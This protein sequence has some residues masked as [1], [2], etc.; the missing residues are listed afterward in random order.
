MGVREEQWLALLIY[1]RLPRERFL[2]VKKPEAY[3]AYRGDEHL[4][5]MFSGLASRRICVVVRTVQR[6]EIHGPV[7]DLVGGQ[8][9]AASSCR[10]ACSGVCES[11]VQ[12]TCSRLEF[13][14]S[15]QWERQEMYGARRHLL[16]QMI[17]KGRS[18]PTKLQCMRARIGRVRRV[19]HQRTNDR[20]RRHG[21]CAQCA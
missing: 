7:R 4:V 9:A 16:Q 13:G 14:V 1:S 20:P 19:K 15:L 8:P 3:H 12:D 2:K 5:V 21:S 11:A 10:S 17:W 18:S 6:K